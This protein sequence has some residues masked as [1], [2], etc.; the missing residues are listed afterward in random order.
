MAGDGTSPAPIADLSARR[1]L[2]HLDRIEVLHAAAHPLGRVEQHTG[3][4]AA[5]RNGVRNEQDPAKTMQELTYT[6]QIVLSR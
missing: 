1:K 5:H 6:C 4:G 3:L 2:Q